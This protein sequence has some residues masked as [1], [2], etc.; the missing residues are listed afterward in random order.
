MLS[1]TEIEI[2]LALEKKGGK[3]NISDLADYVKGSYTTIYKSVDNLK[4]LGLLE[5]RKADRFPFT[6]IIELTEKG[7]KVA[8]Y[9]EEIRKIVQ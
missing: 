2:L 4:Q 5:E 6:R 8:E 3:L 9:L 1:R 7:R